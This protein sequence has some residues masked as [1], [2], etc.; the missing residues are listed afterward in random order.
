MPYKIGVTNELATDE[1]RKNIEKIETESYLNE[2]EP[3]I[4][5]NEL[6]KNYTEENSEKQKV[7]IREEEEEERNIFYV[8]KIKDVYDKAKKLKLELLSSHNNYDIFPIEIN[9]L[10]YINSKRTE[11]DGI[12]YFGCEKDGEREIENKN[13]LPLDISLKPMDEILDDKFY[14]R[15]FQ[16]KFNPD[17]LNYYIKDLGHGFG[18]FIK[19][20]DWT[21]IRNNFLLNIGENYIVFSLGTENEKDMNENYVLN[22]NN[23][24]NDNSINIKIFSG[25]VK[26]SVL[27]FIPSNCPITIGRSNDA[28]IFIDDNMLSRIHCTID[29]RDEKWM[30]KDGNASSNN[31]EVKK[32]TNGSWVYAYEDTLVTDKMTFKSNHNLFVCN[33]IEKH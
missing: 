20:T 13:F 4:L 31:E 17:D 8:I 23:I 7:T 21:E 12:T 6:Y 1:K 11:K 15:H 22:D 16:I 25:N 29:Y 14:G 32:S 9:P 26:Q 24:T 27:S 18:T 10:G 2:P 28:S 33:F 19:I 5:K 30:I 3:D